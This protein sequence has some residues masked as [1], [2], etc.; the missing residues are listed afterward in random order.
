MLCPENTATQLVGD[1]P[2][3]TYPLD[4][5][6][7]S[8]GEYNNT[9]STLTQVDF[10]EFDF[11]S[12]TL[13]QGSKT[14]SQ[15]LLST[16][17]NN[18]YGCTWNPKNG[19]CILYSKNNNNN[20]S[21]VKNSLK[22]EPT[23]SKCLVPFILTK[24]K[25]DN[26][27]LN[28]KYGKPD[29][30]KRISLN[31][32]SVVT[33]DK[34]QPRIMNNYSGVECRKVL[35]KANPSWS[36]DSQAVKDMY[37]WCENNEDKQVCNDFCRIYPG[38]CNKLPVDGIVYVGIAVFL[39]IP[40]VF[41]S[42]KIHK[43]RNIKVTPGPNWWNHPKGSSS[44]W[45]ILLVIIITVIITFAIL[46]IIKLVKYFKHGN[47]FFGN[48]P[49]YSGNTV[50]P[51]D[52]EFPC[53]YLGWVKTSNNLKSKFCKLGG[54]SPSFP[55][56]LSCQ[57]YYCSKNSDCCA[58]NFE[59]D[60]TTGKCRFVTPQFNYDKKW[61][62]KD[63]SAW[64]KGSGIFSCTLPTSA[65]PLYST[66]LPGTSRKNLSSCDSGLYIN[67]WPDITDYYNA[68]YDRPHCICHTPFS[69]DVKQGDQQWVNVPT[70]K[71]V[72]SDPDIHGNWQKL[73]EKY[74]ELKGWFRPFP[75]VKDEKS[76][77]HASLICNSASTDNCS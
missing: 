72:V 30:S 65:D 53:S 13:S 49:D 64:C 35:L 61:Y 10:S 41:I 5:M 69:T 32:A 48:K 51:P 52:T 66:P 24:K 55:T 17:N 62:R 73:S 21:N 28:I 77:K 11:T 50:F 43:I 59:Y 75:W 56:E 57:Q 71:F 58:K 34:E 63:D 19:T 6:C 9:G 60:V 46:G 67:C 7:I 74:K 36:D 40:L 76:S 29:N 25:N 42:V 16:Y 22:D 3:K 27:I 18:S 45:K 2:A 23:H 12:K 14:L 33:P 39:I 38:L 15:C 1:C 44:F 54:G 26:K 68:K 20:I 4:D 47:S 37:S 31:L 8:I 70:D